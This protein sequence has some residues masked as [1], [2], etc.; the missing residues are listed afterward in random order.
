M[1]KQTYLPT[2]NHSLTKRIILTP[3]H[4]S[5]SITVCSNPSSFYFLDFNP[6]IFVRVWCAFVKALF[7]FLQDWAASG[8]SFPTSP[9]SLST[10][11]KASF[12]FLFEISKARSNF[13]FVRLVVNNTILCFDTS[14][15]KRFSFSSETLSYLSPWPIFSPRFL[16]CY[17]FVF[18]S[19]FIFLIAKTNFCI[20]CSFDARIPLN[21]FIWISEAR[22]CIYPTAWFSAI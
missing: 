20:F 12:A 9:S 14:S 15:I 7:M 18:F 13:S 16:S 4:S 19:Y 6:S 1:T 3:P 11:S 10:S 5:R 2:T 22:F 21:Y 17:S 8:L